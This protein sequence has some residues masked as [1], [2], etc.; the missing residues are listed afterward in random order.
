MSLF[1]QEDELWDFLPKKR[2]IKLW[3]QECINLSSYNKPKVGEASVD[4]II[5]HH[6]QLLKTI[7]QQ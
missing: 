1:Q 5:S 6:Q 3:K 7:L 4:Q 2:I